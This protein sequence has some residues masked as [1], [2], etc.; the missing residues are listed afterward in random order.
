VSRTPAPPDNPSQPA[1]T[2]GE[3]AASALKALIRKRP[4]PAFRPSELPVGD[5]DSVPPAK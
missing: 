1:P 5:G 4:P 2:S 3:G